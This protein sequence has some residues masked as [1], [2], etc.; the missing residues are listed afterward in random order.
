MSKEEILKDP[1]WIAEMKDMDANAKA[2]YIAEM[3]YFS[4]LGICNEC[5]NGDVDNSG[6]CL[7]YNMPLFVI[8][9]RKKRCKRFKDYVNK[10]VQL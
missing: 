1:F 4:S 6:K 10:E 9:G 2:A 3:Q 5:V 8:G 7:A